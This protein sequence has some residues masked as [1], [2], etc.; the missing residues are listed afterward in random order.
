MDL[1]LTDTR[2][3]PPISR[4]DLS[5]E[6]QLTTSQYVPPTLSTQLLPKTQENIGDSEPYM[7]RENLPSPSKTQD[8]GENKK[9]I[10]PVKIIVEPELELNDDLHPNRTFI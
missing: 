3:V 2:Q 5:P 6:V 9:S 4:T 1:N 10:E 8:D 7:A